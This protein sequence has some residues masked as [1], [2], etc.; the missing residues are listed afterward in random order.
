M[1]CS[2][3]QFHPEISI[4]SSESNN[5]ILTRC[6]RFLRTCWQSCDASLAGTHLACE[7]IR[8][9]EQWLPSQGSGVNGGSGGHRCCSN[10]NKTQHSTLGREIQFTGCNTWRICVRKITYRAVMYKELNTGSQCSEILSVSPQSVCIVRYWTS[11]TWVDRMDINREEHIAN[12]LGSSPTMVGMGRC[13]LRMK[14][15]GSL[16]VAKDMGSACSWHWSEFPS[17]SFPLSSSFRQPLPYRYWTVFSV[18]FISFGAC[19]SLL[20]CFLFIFFAFL[21][22]QCFLSSFL[23]D[24]VLERLFNNSFR[25]RFF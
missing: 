5:I 24:N 25:W 7:P 19:L 18:L 8:R 20:S 14:V 6:C 11:I 22:S 16:L 21:F 4:K 15:G 9:L 3:S 17:F 1:Q 10:L 13:G 12:C 23:L 2:S